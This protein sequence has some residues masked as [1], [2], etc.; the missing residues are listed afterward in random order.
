MLLKRQEQSLGCSYCSEEEENK[1]SYKSDKPILNLKFNFIYAMSELLLQT[2][3][4]EDC[5]CI[6]SGTAT[7]SFAAVSTGG[8]W[9]TGNGE[10][11]EYREK[12]GKDY[13]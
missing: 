13:I 7:D 12:E 5:L 9:V 1:L 6:F 11:K 10:G 3:T 8:T 2:K 4:C